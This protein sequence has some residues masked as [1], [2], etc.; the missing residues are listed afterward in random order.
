MLNLQEGHWYKGKTGKPR[1]IDWMRGVDVNY[2][3]WDDLF[4]K[5]CCLATF[6]CSGREDLGTKEPKGDWP[7]LKTHNC[8]DCRTRKT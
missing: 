1:K 2:C 3:R 6:R 7:C 5:N 4:N 8:M